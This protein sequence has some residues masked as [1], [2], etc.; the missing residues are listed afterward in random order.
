MEVVLDIIIEVVA[1]GFGFLAAKV[2]NFLK[3]MFKR[4]HQ[5]Q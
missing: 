4:K 2:I 3:K 1:E 5:D